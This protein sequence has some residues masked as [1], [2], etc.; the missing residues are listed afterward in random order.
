VVLVQAKWILAHVSTCR[1]HFVSHSL[2]AQSGLN[3]TETPR[4]RTEPFGDYRQFL[5]LSLR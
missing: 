1:A 2:S 5:G 4:L 3:G